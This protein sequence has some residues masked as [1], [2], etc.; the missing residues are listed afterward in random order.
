M[1]EGRAELL[2]EGE[3]V[4]P[5]AGSVVMAEPGERHQPTWIDPV[6]GVRWVIIKERSAPGTR[7]CVSEG[8]G[9]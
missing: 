4:S 6:H 7:H 1:L 9:G 5:E 3:R 8:S 2:I